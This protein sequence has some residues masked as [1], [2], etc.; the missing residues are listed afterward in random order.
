LNRACAPYSTL[1]TLPMENAINN[2]LK[3][4]GPSTRV[5]TLEGSPKV[6]REE[7]LPDINM[8]CYHTTLVWDIEIM[9]PQTNDL[10]SWSLTPMQ[11][12]LRRAV[13][14]TLRR[15]LPKT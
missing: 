3:S 8:K 11:V 7:A 15:M 4:F 14:H 5:S 12:A 13:Q 1:I 9:Q 6:E 2:N 10:H